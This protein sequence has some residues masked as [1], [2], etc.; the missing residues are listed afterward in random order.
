L[1]GRRIRPVYVERPMLEE[2]LETMNGR[3]PSLMRIGDPERTVRLLAEA[4]FVTASEAQAVDVDLELLQS[5][6]LERLWEI[7]DNDKRSE[8]VGLDALLPRV[9]QLLLRPQPEAAGLR[10]VGEDAP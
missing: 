4:S 6:D 1:T 7:I 2:M 8:A 9:H 10:D 3:R 5:T